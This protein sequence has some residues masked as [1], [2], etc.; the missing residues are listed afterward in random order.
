MEVC[1]VCIKQTNKQ[2]NKE[3]LEQKYVILDES[4]VAFYSSSNGPA[5]SFLCPAAFVQEW[6]N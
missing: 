6:K 1:C 2:T 4:F 3:N 5:L